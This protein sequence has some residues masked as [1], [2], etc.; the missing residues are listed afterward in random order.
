MGKENADNARKC[1]KKNLITVPSFT[2]VT[3]ILYYSITIIPRI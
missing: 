1:H 2:Y 3:Y